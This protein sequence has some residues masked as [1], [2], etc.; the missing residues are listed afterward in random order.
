MAQAERYGYTVARLR[1]MENRLLDSG[2]FQRMLDAEDLQ[3]ALKVLNETCYSSWLVEMKNEG[4]FDG[5]IEAELNYVYRETEQFVPDRALVTLCKMPYDFHNI[6]VLLKSSFLQKAGGVRRWDLLTWLGNVSPEFL[7]ESLESEDYR[8]LPFGLRS[9]VPRCLAQWEQFHDILEIERQ[10]DDL[11]FS[12]M[13]KLAAKLERKG[14]MEWVQGRIDAE[15]VRNLLRLR[16]LQVENSRIAGFMHEGGIISIE[17]L[18]SLTS[19]PLESWGRILAYTD[20]TG[21]LAELQ[22][23]SDFDRLIVDVEKALDDYV[24][25]VVEQTRFSTA[26]PEYVL[27]YLWLKEMEAKNVRIILVGKANGANR[28]VLRGLLRHV[29]G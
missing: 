27:Y 15:N 13:L 2:A 22:E 16:R 29:S 4:A 19:E 23:I 14:V 12:E 6:K 11:L 24:L 8:L 21:A 10:L 17:R 26:S 18:L 5:A 20:L 3:G 9:A 28:D 7:I 1:A 25:R